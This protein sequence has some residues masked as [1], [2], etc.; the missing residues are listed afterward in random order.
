MKVNP[1]YRLILDFALISILCAVLW[2]I[3][4]GTAKHIGW[5]DEDTSVLFSMVLSTLYLLFSL[6][7]IW[8]AVNKLDGKS[9]IYKKKR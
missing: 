3:L 1:K 7:T 5:V 8:L 9:K 2:G 6:I 4:G